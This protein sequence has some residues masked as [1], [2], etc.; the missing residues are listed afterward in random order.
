MLLL[1]PASTLAQGYPGLSGGS[2]ANGG[3]GGG[4]GG[5][6]SQ[7]PQRAPVRPDIA[8]DETIQ[9]D[10]RLSEQETEAAV[11]QRRAQDDLQNLQTM[12]PTASPRTPALQ[13]AQ[14]L[15]MAAIIRENSKNPP[16]ILPTRRLS[17][18]MLNAINKPQVKENGLW[19]KE[20]QA[21]QYVNLL[22][23]DIKSSAPNEKRAKIMAAREQIA[24]MIDVNL[25]TLA[26]PESTS[27]AL[28]MTPRAIQEKKAAAA[29]TN[30]QLKK[31]LQ[32]IR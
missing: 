19:P 6:T 32:Q 11:R 8:T 23:R 9:E 27:L 1:S 17:N 25:I 28:G 2:T 13:N 24:N 22:F 21:I 29:A 12:A 14:D 15:E 26:A 4:Y 10:G 16:S 7:A 31:A 20:A 18:T 5:L 3:Q 30:E